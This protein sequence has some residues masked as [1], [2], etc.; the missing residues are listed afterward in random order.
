VR[1]STVL[2]VVAAVRVVLPN[3]GHLCFHINRL[4]TGGPL[5]VQMTDKND[6]ELVDAQD[7][8]DAPKVV[9]DA[10][11]NKKRKAEDGAQPAAAANKRYGV[12]PVSL[13]LETRIA[14][15]KHACESQHLTVTWLVRLSKIADAG[16][17][18]DADFRTMDQFHRLV[19]EQLWS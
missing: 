2:W 12:V 16:I 3:V 19:A 5:S 9:A 10:S 13:D 1:A 11:S 4:L 18:I 15:S 6:I 17:T 14:Q 8:K 7:K